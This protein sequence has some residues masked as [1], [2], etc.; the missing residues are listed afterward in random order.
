LG[1]PT[2]A[3]KMMLDQIQAVSGVL[4]L[5]PEVW[6]PTMVGRTACRGLDCQLHAEIN[7]FFF[8]KLVANIK[9]GDT[10]VANTE[11]WDP[12]SWPKE[13]K[14]VGFYEAPRGA[15]SHW[16]QIKD[17]KTANYQC[18]VPT[19]WNACP[20]DDK[21]GHGAYEMAMM[22]TKVQVPDKPLEIAKV[23]RSFDPCMACATH[24]YNTKGE[25]IK[26]VTTDPYAATRMED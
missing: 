14:G 23:I 25:R 18:I 1:D 7:K 10:K 9:I 13:A 6:M 21:A 20:R 12:S 11:K 5:A 15:L 17:T 19:T 22:D 26:T 2:W 3:E 8:D 16:I 4:G 24:M